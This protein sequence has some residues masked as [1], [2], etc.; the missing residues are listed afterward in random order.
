LGWI[1]GIATNHQQKNQE[2]DIDICV[3]R[4]RDGKDG[5]GEKGDKETL[6]D[7]EI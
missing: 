6:K 1:F 2:S 4:G 7:G 3:K 5:K